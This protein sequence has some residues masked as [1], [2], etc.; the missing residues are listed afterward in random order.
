MLRER[1]LWPHGCCL[2]SKN[3][4]AGGSG[5]GGKEREPIL[6]MLRMACQGRERLHS[7]GMQGSNPNPL[8]R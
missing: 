3:D 6:V 7:N 4:Y 1:V 2:T 8:S 5:V